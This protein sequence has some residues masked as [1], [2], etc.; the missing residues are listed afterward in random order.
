MRSDAVGRASSIVPGAWRRV[1]APTPARARTI[2]SPS[3]AGA[4]ARVG[5]GYRGAVLNCGGRV[6]ATDELRDR[7]KQAAGLSRRAEG[8]A[9]EADRSDRALLRPQGVPEAVSA[10]SRR[11]NPAVPRA[12]ITAP[13]PKPA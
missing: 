7:A 11:S 4:G 8:L 5:A 3:P 9:I 2:T 13:V 1:A 10:A 12:P 6:A